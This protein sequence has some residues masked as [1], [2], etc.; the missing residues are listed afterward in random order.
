MSEITGNPILDGII[1]QVDQENEEI[2]IVLDG[3]QE[4]KIKRLKNAIESNRVSQ[5]AEQFIKRCINPPPSWKPYLPSEVLEEDY[6]LLRGLGFIRQLLIPMATDIQVLKLL[7]DPDLLL[8]ISSKVKLAMDISSNKGEVKE[9]DE[10]KNDSE[11]T[12]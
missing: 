6:D 8:D 7:N 2:S 10:L 5:K 12:E 1:K 9:L 4:L 11:A 3:G